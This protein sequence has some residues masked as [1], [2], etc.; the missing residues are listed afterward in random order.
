M[1]WKQQD[2]GIYLVNCLGIIYNK[3]TNK[4]LI[5]R[6]E[7]DPHIKELS[8]SFPGGRPKYDESLEEGLKR[9]IKTKT[10]LNVSVK[11]LI[12]ARTYP[13]KPE[14][15]SLF[16]DCEL[17]DGKEQ[18]GELFKEIKWIS[19]AEVK[20]YFTTSIHP[21]ILKFLESL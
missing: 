5:G 9:E 12:L 7:N 20:K 14:F 13:E 10:G 1:D 16:Y 18:A 21:T 2:R 4:I 17:I 19:P 8:W 6:R 15:L 11:N 3:K